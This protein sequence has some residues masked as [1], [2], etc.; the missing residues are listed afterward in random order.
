MFGHKN[1]EPSGDARMRARWF[2]VT[3]ASRASLGLLLFDNII[4]TIML[5]GA[6]RG[7]NLSSTY[8]YFRSENTLETFALG[9]CK[10]YKGR[11]ESGYKIGIAQRL[12]LFTL[13]ERIEMNAACAE[14]WSAYHLS[15]RR[16]KR[17][18]YW[19]YQG[20]FAVRLT[21]IPF[22]MAPIPSKS[23]YAFQRAISR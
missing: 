12:S 8:V 16:R 7:I 4:Y 23:S 22:N 15:L 1:V 21:Y 13:R 3:Y 9:G 19:P 2:S 5:I 18:A 20:I 11:I 17:F 10:I 14:K 6:H